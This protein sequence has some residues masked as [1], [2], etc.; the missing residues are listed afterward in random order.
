FRREAKMAAALHHPNIV[1]MIDVGEQAGRYF[2]VMKYMP[3]GSLRDR[4]AKDGAL[5]FDQALEIVRQAAAALDALHRQGLV[6]RDLK[7][8]NLLFDEDGTLRLSDLGFARALSEA[9]VSQQSSGGII[10]TPHY[11]APEAW[12]GDVSPAVDQY[13]LACIFCEMLTGKILFSGETPAE[14]MTR[15]VLQGATFPETLAAALPQGLADVLRKAVAADPQQRYAFAWDFTRDLALLTEGRLPALTPLAAPTPAAVPAPCPQK[16]EKTKKKNPTWLV[17]CA[18]IAVLGL[19]AGA[20]APGALLRGLGNGGDRANRA[21]EV[22]PTLVSLLVEVKTP[23]LL[24]TQEPPPPTALP[25]F[26]PLVAATELALSPT[27]TVALRPSDPTWTG[28]FFANQ[29]LKLQVTSTRA[30]ALISFDGG[31]SNPAQADDHMMY[32][33]MV[34]F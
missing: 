6:H 2:L 15:H 14:V 34:V 32:F 1:T 9:S 3:G 28:E 21:D 17:G 24:P 12:D 25:T 33:W 29:E 11:L 10:G 19:M 18:A 22:P 27:S 4:L 20:L 13:A 31:R 8:A 23:E 26:T 5:P 16:A 30:D 7:P